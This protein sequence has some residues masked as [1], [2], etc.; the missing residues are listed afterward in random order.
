[1]QAAPNQLLSIN[2]RLNPTYIVQYVER[3]AASSCRSTKQLAAEL[4][5]RNNKPLPVMS[6][7]ASKRIRNAVNW[8]AASALPKRVYCAADNRTYSFRLNFITLTLPSLGLPVSDHQFKS[9]LLKNFLARMEYRHGLKNYVWKVETQANGNIHA[10]LTTDC[11]IHWR[12]IR[13]VWND[14]LIKAGYMKQFASLH[15]HS[16]PNSTDVKSVRAVKD[17]AAYL[18]KYFSKSENDRRHVSGRLW[19]CSYSLS[20]KNPCSIHLDPHD[21]LNVLPPLVSSTCEAVNVQSE[22]DVFGRRRH[23]ATVF[24]MSPAF[25]RTLSHSIIGQHYAAR[26][27]YI[28]TGTF[29]GDVFSS[30]FINSPYVQ[31]DAKPKDSGVVRPS[32]TIRNQDK[33]DQSPAHDFAE[34]RKRAHQFALQFPCY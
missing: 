26:L 13:D 34:V 27:N 21:T 30:H 10:H 14:L 9:R 33:S 6:C 17:L 29:A 5:L 32:D 15:G 4:N 23:L 1:M 25:W 11:F 19:S 18:A 31:F 3:D 7:K 2:L 24:F 28:R 20:D 16:D 22:P 12:E 8:L